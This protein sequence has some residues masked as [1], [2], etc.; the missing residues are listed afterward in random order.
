MSRAMNSFRAQNRC[1]NQR[2]AARIVHQGKVLLQTTTSTRYW[3]LPGGRVEFGESSEQALVR[4]LKEELALP[5]S[6]M[7]PV[8]LIENF[9]SEDRISYHELLMIYTVELSDEQFALIAKPMQHREESGLVLEFEWH[10]VET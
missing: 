9:F 10:S 2:V 8:W 5:Q 4:E 7:R 3:T 1:F 6:H